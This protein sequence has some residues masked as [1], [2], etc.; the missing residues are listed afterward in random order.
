M[1][2]CRTIYQT[3]GDLSQAIFEQNRPHWMTSVGSWTNTLNLTWNNVLQSV[4]V[5]PNT[6]PLRM[7]IVHSATT[8]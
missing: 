2:V 4:G 7:R 3:V 6:R 5:Q 1:Q 8:S